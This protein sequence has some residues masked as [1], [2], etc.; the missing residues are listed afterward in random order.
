MT[1]TQHALVPINPEKQCSACRSQKS[2]H[3]KRH[4]NVCTAALSRR[5]CLPRC[6]ASTWSPRSQSRMTCTGSTWRALAP[7]VVPRH[8]GGDYGP[9][10]LQLLCYGCNTSCLQAN[11][12]V[13]WRRIRRDQRLKEARDFLCMH[14]LGRD[15]NQVVQGLQ[16]NH[17]AG[18]GSANIHMSSRTVRRSM[19]AHTCDTILDALQDY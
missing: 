18:Q 2:A 19:Y 17:R 9:K 13:A 10:N 5:P 3:A 14:P 16:R 8:R 15:E 11:I 7:S 4:R 6:A 12:V 1:A